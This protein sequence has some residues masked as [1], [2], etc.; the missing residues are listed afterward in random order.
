MTPG[1]ASFASLLPAVLAFACL[2][3]P[4]LAAARAGSGPAAEP[5]AGDPFAEC[6]RRL[7]AEPGSREAASCFYV[8]AN[9]D[10]D[11]ARARLERHLAAAPDDPWLLYYLGNVRWPSLDPAVADLYRTA[12][13][14]LAERGDLTGETDARLNLAIYLRTLGLRDDAETA[15]DEAVAAARA[16]GDPLL[17]ARTQVERATQAMSRGTDLSAQ[18]RDLRRIEPLVFPDGPYVLRRDYVRALGQAAH[19]L[20][21]WEEALGHWHRY[22]ELVRE[23]DDRYGEAIATYNMAISTLEAHPDDTDRAEALALVRAALDAAEAT[24]NAHTAALSHSVL[25]RLTEGGEA[26]RHLERCV[27]IAEGVRQSSELA[28]CLGAL[29]EERVDDDPAE[30][31]RLLDRALA[32]GL[33]S[34]SPWPLV[35]TWGN[36]MNVEWRSRPREEALAESLRALEVIETLRRLQPGE[37]GRVGVGSVWSD[38]Y[39]WLAGRLLDGDPTAREVA[40]AFALAERA[41]A[42]TLL[43]TLSARD[44]S[45]AAAGP[46]PEHRRVL[47][48]IVAIHRRL[49]DPRVGGDDR[50]LALARLDELEIEEAALREGAGVGAPGELGES[51][52]AGLAEVESL[53]APNQALLAFQLGRWR[54]FYGDFDGGSWLL[55]VTAGGTSVHRLPE[56]GEVEGAVRIF[57]GLIERRDGAEETAAAA[58]Y[59]R[60]LADALA[61]LPAEVDELVLIADGPLHLLPFAALRGGAGRQPLAVRYRLSHAPSSTFWVRWRQRPAP[62]VPAAALVLADPSPARPGG[63]PAGAAELREAS[64][65]RGGGWGALPHARREGRMIARRLAPNAELWI[66]DDASE[67]RLKAGGADGLPAL[68]FAAHALVDG[69]RPGR[70]AV[71]LAP[72]SGEEDGLLQP[73]EIAALDLADRLVVLSACR[74]A[75]GAVLRGEGVMSLARAFF[76][77]GSRTVVAGLW[78]LRDDDTRAL[79]GRLYDHLAA[80]ATVD[81]AL[82]EAQRDLIA[83]GYPPAA[84]A[85]L[86]V[87]GDGAWQPFVAAER[88]GMDGGRIAALAGA[89]LLAALALRF[90]IAGLAARRRR[91]L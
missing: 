39:F 29:A 47:E 22:R 34:G 51:D 66:G 21:R 50:R 32:A 55:A 16:S 8:A 52:F 75:A 42:R 30:A 79:A 40:V 49:L 28:I 84:W 4:A 46:P 12:A 69:D 70:S 19:L 85:G 14:R 77:A 80:G 44:D 63:A 67:A 36:R 83:D 57:L 64:L 54:D 2:A 35:H 41:R 82:A 31:R 74:G 60:L 61:A 81:R 58:L 5:T 27:E 24:G 1:W 65:D 3:A 91:R 37:T 71:L 7:A 25:A 38:A 48:E 43:E 18:Y 88:G 9:A 72:G 90:A 10:R 13:R 17:I 56:R 26:R 76:Q 89:G 20:G 11:Q 53:L 86:V 33:D 87:L 15:L 73:R 6:E 78:P 59:D 68:H 23:R 45:G 62:P